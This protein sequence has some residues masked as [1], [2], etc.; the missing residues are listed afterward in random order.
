M[1]LSTNLLFGVM[2]GVL[3][4]LWLSG[5]LAYGLLK[6]WCREYLKSKNGEV[7][8]DWYDEWRLRHYLWFGPF[9]LLVA[10][11]VYKRFNFRKPYFCLKMPKELLKKRS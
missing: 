9:G 7:F 11:R 2:L 10:R 1:G 3:F 4:A 6:G 8:Y 5:F